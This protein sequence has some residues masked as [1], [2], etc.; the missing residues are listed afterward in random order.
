MYKSVRFNG[1][2][3]TVNQADHLKKHNIVYE[4]SAYKGHDG[5]PIGNGDKEWQVNIIGRFGFTKGKV[6]HEGYTIFQED[7]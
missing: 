6:K 4:T 7:G 5:L 1:K 3:L 2:K